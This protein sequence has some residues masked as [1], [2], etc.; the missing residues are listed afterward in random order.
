MDK[1]V[2]YVKGLD[3]DKFI[4]NRKKVFADAYKALKDVVRDNMLKAMNTLMKEN[5]AE[6]IKKAKADD[7]TE[8]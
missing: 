6:Q 5:I 3:H 2:I 1:D 7:D 8:K 4:E